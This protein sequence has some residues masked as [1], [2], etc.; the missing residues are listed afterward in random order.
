M[1]SHPFRFRYYRR[2]FQGLAGLQIQRDLFLRPGAH[3]PFLEGHA[4]GHALAVFVIPRGTG[5][6]QDSGNAR[7]GEEEK[8]K[9]LGLSNFILFS[10]TFGDL[11]DFFANFERLILGCVEADLCK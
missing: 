10:K 3:L 6:Q 8:R 7:D 11:Y 4:K 5:T 1:V 2:L 9:R